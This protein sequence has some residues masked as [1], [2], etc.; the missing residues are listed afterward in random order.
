MQWIGTPEEKKPLISDFNFCAKWSETHSRPINLGEFGVNENADMASRARYLS[1]ISELAIKN[2]FSF[3]LWGFREIFRVF[4]E[5]SGKW[6][7]PL[8]D[9]LIPK[10]H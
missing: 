4:D 6:Q 8:V 9:A 10:K 1:F 5:Q 7:Q 2:D 3:H